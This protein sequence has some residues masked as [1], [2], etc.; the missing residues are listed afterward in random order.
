MSY[1]SL[2]TI[3]N[4]YT[5]IH[6]TLYVSYRSMKPPAGLV[7]GSAR[8]ASTSA[9]VNYII[10]QVTSNVSDTCFKAINQVHT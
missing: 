2:S 1:L 9:A 6:P 5:H 7:E 4:A 10:S 8:E 3:Q